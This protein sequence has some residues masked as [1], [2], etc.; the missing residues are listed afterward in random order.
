MFT[1]THL[2]QL[3]D[4]HPQS[5]AKCLDNLP[6]KDVFDCGPNQFSIEADHSDARRAVPLP[7]E[8]RRTDALGPDGRNTT[9]PGPERSWSR[10]KR[11]NRPNCWNARPMSENSGTSASSAAQGGDLCRDA[12]TKP[13]S[14]WTRR[15]SRQPDPAVVGGNDTTRHTLSGS[16]YA[17]NKNP[18]STRSAQILH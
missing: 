12:N 7:G 4:Q 9:I 11:A 10:R 18:I 5:L 2:D 8:D 16:I 6:K 14:T 13:L 3:L 17:L 1:P 15:I